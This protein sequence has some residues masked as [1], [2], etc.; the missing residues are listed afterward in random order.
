VIRDT[1]RWPQFQWLFIPNH[2]RGEKKKSVVWDN[3][4]RQNDLDAFGEASAIL[5][6]IMLMAEGD[7]FVGKFTSNVDRIAF[8]LMAARKG[9]L[10]PYSSLDST[11]CLDWGKPAGVGT[12][13][14]FQC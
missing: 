10:V 9:G 6:D 7:A 5:A 3:L 1:S 4:L 2:D 12:Y 13:G 11:W 14:T 8:A